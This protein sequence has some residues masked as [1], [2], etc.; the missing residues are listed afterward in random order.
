MALQPVY[1]KGVRIFS[2]TD[3][4]RQHFFQWIHD[5]NDV[6]A[7]L[8]NI[9]AGG[10]LREISPIILDI[11]QEYTAVSGREVIP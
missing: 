1:I 2:A 8:D 11:C 7:T 3:D 9:A 4:V 5:T 10:P 6:R